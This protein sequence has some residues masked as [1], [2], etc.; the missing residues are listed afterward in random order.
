[1]IGRLR[2]RLR[3]LLGLHLH[4]YELELPEGQHERIPLYVRDSAN[5]YCDGDPTPTLVIERVSLVRTRITIRDDDER[6]TADDLDRLL[7]PEPVPA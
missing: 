7:E 1:M 6:L 2:I 5:L 3:H 4:V